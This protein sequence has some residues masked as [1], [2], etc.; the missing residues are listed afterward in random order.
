MYA[1]TCT[2]EKNVFTWVCFAPRGRPPQ[3]LWLVEM[4]HTLPLVSRSSRQCLRLPPMAGHT[5]DN[6]IITIT[7]ANMVARTRLFSNVTSTHLWLSLQFSLHPSSLSSSPPPLSLSFSLPSLHSPLPPHTHLTL[8]RT[9]IYMQSWTH[10]NSQRNR[11]SPGSDELNVTRHSI[12]THP[13]LH[14]H[15]PQFIAGLINGHPG[16]KVVHTAEHHINRL[17]LLQVTFA[18]ERETEQWRIKPRQW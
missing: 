9:H 17:A 5:A 2:G 8:T 13:A 16:F 11:P 14:P 15:L 10:Y 4:L 6:R 12:L 18:G 7:I 1:Y 3:P